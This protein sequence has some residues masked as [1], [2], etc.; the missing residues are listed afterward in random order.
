MEEAHQIA[1][2][3]FLYFRLIQENKQGSVKLDSSYFLDMHVNNN[4]VK[5]KF[6]QK[7]SLKLDKWER[8]AISKIDLDDSLYYDMTEVDSVLCFRYVKPFFF[9]I[10]KKIII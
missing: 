3:D 6:I 9:P 2:R 8:K 10:K 7:H 4:G 5:S 1:K